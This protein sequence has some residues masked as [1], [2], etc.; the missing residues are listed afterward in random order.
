MDFGVSIRNPQA[1]GRSL[2]AVLAILVLLPAVPVFA[3]NSIEGQ[4]FGAGAPIAKS[5]VTLWSASADAPKQLAQTR[6]GDDGHF[7][8]SAE[9][10]PDSILY[11]VAKGGEPTAN[12]GGGDNPAIALLAVIGNKPPAHVVINEFTTVASVWT[13]AQFLDGTAIKGNPLGLRIAAG[14]VPNFVDLATG[15]YG[16]MI[17]DGFNS[18]ETPTMANFGTLSNILAGCITNVTQDACK[19]LFVAAVGRDGKNTHRHTHRGDIN[20]AQYGL[21]A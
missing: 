16:E 5:T 11:I 20:C 13:N 18:T 17:Q 3:V 10:S 19:S 12:K 21:Q 15:G 1:V 9:G 2:V 6:S 8:L 7:T 14:N 4:V